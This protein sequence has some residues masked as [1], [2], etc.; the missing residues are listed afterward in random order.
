MYNTARY[1]RLRFI[2]ANSRNPRKTCHTTTKPLTWKS[3][4]QEYIPFPLL[5]LHYANIMQVLQIGYITINKTRPWQENSVDGSNKVTLS[6]WNIAELK[7]CVQSNPVPRGGNLAVSCE[8]P[9]ICRTLNTQQLL[10]RCLRTSRETSSTAAMASR[11]QRYGDKNIHTD[12]ET[13][14]SEM[15]VISDQQTPAEHDVR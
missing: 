13:D 9:S 8:I 2:L 3:T 5:A 7:L 1:I 11:V 6:T 15:W 14:K 4:Y 12:R 10:C